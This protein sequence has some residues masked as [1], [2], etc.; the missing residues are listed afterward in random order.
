MEASSPPPV[1]AAAAVEAEAPP[2]DEGGGGNGGHLLDA[3]IYEPPAER[4]R[5]YQQVSGGI[6]PPFIA[7]I[8]MMREAD[9]FLTRASP[10]PFRRP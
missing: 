4:L 9:S 8:I 7:S 3:A 5:N 6:G 2:G 1:E 10:P